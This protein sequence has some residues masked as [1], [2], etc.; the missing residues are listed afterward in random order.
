MI[1]IRELLELLSQV[2][3]NIKTLNT[4]KADNFRIDKIKCYNYRVQDD[5][6]P[7]ENKTIHS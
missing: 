6:S 2:K 7:Q 5:I 4:F 3:Q 1:F